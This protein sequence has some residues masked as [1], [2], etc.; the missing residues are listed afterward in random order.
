MC[1]RA[2]RSVVRTGLVQHHAGESSE[3]TAEHA[4]K[5]LS[6]RL[7]RKNQRA[8]WRAF[9]C[10]KVSAVSSVLARRRPWTPSAAALRDTAVR[11]MVLPHRSWR[12][13]G[14]LGC[15]SC[16]VV[17]RM[18]RTVQLDS[19]AGAHT[20]ARI[21]LCSHA[22]LSTRDGWCVAR[23]GVLAALR[24]TCQ[25]RVGPVTLQF[26]SQRQRDPRVV[27]KKA[28]LRLRPFWSARG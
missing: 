1:S 17:S 21:L 11:V 25:C 13:C 8:V 20:V 14:G 15:G 16:H 19:L 28:R 7:T 5:R 4:E 26:S 6:T 18:V 27:G 24:A 2:H 12:Q 3:L 9:V 10:I 22:H 23:T